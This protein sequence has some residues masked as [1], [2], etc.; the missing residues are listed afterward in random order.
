MTASDHTTSTARVRA[1]R[2]KVLANPRAA[3]AHRALGEQIA[4]RI[5]HKRATVSESQGEDEQ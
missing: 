4:Q 3:D 2:T 1:A 5:E